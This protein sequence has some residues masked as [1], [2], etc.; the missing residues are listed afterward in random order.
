MEQLFG[1][2]KRILCGRNP[3]LTTRQDSREW[4]NRP[5]IQPK[6]RRGGV[7][8]VLH[9]RQIAKTIKKHTTSRIPQRSPNLSPGSTLS[10][11]ENEGR[12]DG[13]PYFIFYFYFSWIWSYVLSNSGIGHFCILRLISSDNRHDENPEQIQQVC[14]PISFAYLRDGCMKKIFSGYNSTPQSSKATRG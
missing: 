5:N 7:G 1:K 12:A 8:G 10:H 4:K 11:F 3:W 6:P 14:C 9:D 13:I 2:K